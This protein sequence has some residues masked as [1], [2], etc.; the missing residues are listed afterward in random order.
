MVL[1]A[2][3]EQA[4][5]EG[6]QRLIGTYVP[7]D[8][9]KLVQE[10]YSKLGF[11]LISAVNGVST[12]EM[13]VSKAAVEGAP[14]TKKHVAPISIQATT[15]QP[16]AGTD[17]SVETKMG[18]LAESKG[19]SDAKE[20]TQIQTDLVQ[21]WQELLDR[22]DIG[23]QDDFFEL[24]GDSLL[25][26]RL[27]IEIEKKFH[28]RFDISIL[29]SH[30]TIENLAR[31]LAPLAGPV[32]QDRKN[33]KVENELVQ[34]WNELL[35]RDNISVSDDFFELGGDSLLGIRLMIEIEKKF[36][37]RFDISIL[38]SNPTIE[39]LA[40]ELAPPESD[41]EAVHIVPMRPEGE[42]A[43][44]FFIHC[45]TGQ[46]KKA[47]RRRRMELSPYPIRVASAIRLAL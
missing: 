46:H 12:Y 5:T 28:R 7:T 14:M 6:V 13:D 2:V 26:V 43:P 3:L 47:Q 29:V 35:D 31:E 27:M 11:Q 38:V 37:R 20:Y 45:G 30:P 16:K 18:I 33:N 41:P 24:G 23:V 44:L 32:L 36:H 40:R 22:E 1:L 39:S 34:I 8:R 9:N 10:H 21:I 19:S 42:S 25:G 15:S 4:K 17:T